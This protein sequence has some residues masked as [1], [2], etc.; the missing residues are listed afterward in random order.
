MENQ[1]F[2]HRLC[3]ARSQVLAPSVEVDVVGVPLAHWRGCQPISTSTSPQASRRQAKRRLKQARRFTFSPGHRHGPLAS[4]H[5]TRPRAHC[6]D[7]LP[8][9]AYPSFPAHWTAGHTV[10][11][12]VGSP[13]HSRTRPPATGIPEPGHWHPAHQPTSLSQALI[14][15]DW[16]TGPL[17]QQSICSVESLSRIKDMVRISN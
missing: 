7:P 4:R 1:G 11:Q 15:T 13:A 6:T 10:H 2:R 9:F 5:T 17:M 12:S 14:Y 16:H 3:D 8:P